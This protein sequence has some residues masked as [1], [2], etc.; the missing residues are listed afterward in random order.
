MNR[1]KRQ[2]QK[3][4]AAQV[5]AESRSKE[6]VADYLDGVTVSQI[7]RK[8]GIHHV[9]VWRIIEKA[10]A[11]WLKDSAEEYTEQLP[12]RMAELEELKRE[13]WEQWHRSKR[14]S[15]QTAEERGDNANGPFTKVSKKTLGRLGNAAYLE[16]IHKTIRT[17]AEMTGLLK[18]SDTNT[19]VPAP[20]FVEIVVDNKDQILSFTEYTKRKQA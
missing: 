8:I 9:T 2:P 5:A 4:K 19:D 14:D 18:Q 7:A 11:E 17:Q 20:L 12:H 16:L 13:A 3:T 10:R 1:R 15:L 6:I